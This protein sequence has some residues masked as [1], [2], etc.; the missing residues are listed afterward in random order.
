MKPLVSAVVN[1]HRCMSSLYHSTTTLHL[2]RVTCFGK[3]DVILQEHKMCVFVCWWV[4]GGR[5]DL[6]M[7]STTYQQL[8]L[9]IYT[10][11]SSLPSEPLLP[12]R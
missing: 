7:Y 4:G 1:I 2:L 8:F 11:A 6:Q 5:G 12:S 3:C 10:I 9:H